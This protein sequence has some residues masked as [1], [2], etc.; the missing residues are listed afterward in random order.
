MGTLDKKQSALLEKVFGIL[1][2]SSGDFT[3]DR[4][5]Y[6]VGEDY[7]LWTDACTDALRERI[8]AMAPLG[9]QVRLRYF[10]MAAGCLSLECLP[11]QIA[12]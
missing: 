2:G 12:A 10:R 8:A 4:L 6:L 9:I 11:A 5:F 1:R 7:A 3:Q